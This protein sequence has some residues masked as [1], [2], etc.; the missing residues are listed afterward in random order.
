MMRVSTFVISPVVFNLNCG[1]GEIPHNSILND[2]TYACLLTIRS[3]DGEISRLIVREDDGEIVNP[4]Y[5]PYFQGNLSFCRYGMQGI[6]PRI[7]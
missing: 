5:R 6:I 4:L 2:K 3:N 1:K 7:Y